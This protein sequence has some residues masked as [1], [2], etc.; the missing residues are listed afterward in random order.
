MSTRQVS[1]TEQ[2]R[3]EEGMTRVLQGTGHTPFPDT[4]GP[5]LLHEAVLARI[6]EES[7]GCP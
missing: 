4:P 6:R 5:P 3:F 2:G 1:D 7:A